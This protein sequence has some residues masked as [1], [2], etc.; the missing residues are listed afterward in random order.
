MEARQD[1]FKVGDWV[2]TQGGIGL[3][4]QVFPQYYQYWEKL[5]DD[6]ARRETYGDN[7]TLA[8]R[9][10][11]KPKSVGEW[12]QD[13]LQVK[14]LCD[15]DLKPYSRVMCFAAKA[16]ANDGTTK[17]QLAKI[18]QILKDPRIADRFHSYQCKDRRESAAWGVLISPE[19][20]TEIKRALENQVAVA[21]MPLREWAAWFEHAFGV[22]LLQAWRRKTFENVV[23][24]TMS[25]PI[26]APDH[27]NEARER[28]FCKVEIARDVLSWT[29]LA[30]RLCGVCRKPRPR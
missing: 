14:R 28:M 7:H 12:V 19:K 1:M 26:D 8:D 17:K 25:L 21:P 15:H 22:D 30:L 4:T 20:A 6:R 18:A 27:Y 23:I 9:F 3:V 2:H 11:G 13:I 16:Y 24:K 10:L 5:S 29:G